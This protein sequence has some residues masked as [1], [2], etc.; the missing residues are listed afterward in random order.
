MIYGVILG[1]W[2]IAVGVYTLYYAF[3]MEKTGMIKAGWIIGRDTQLKESRDLP[4]FV[5]VAKK[6]CFI[7]GWL[8]SIG[9]IL[10]IFGYI[11][12]WYGV[13]A[14]DMLVLIIAYVWFSM[15]IRKAEKKY[16]AVDK[17]EKK[18]RKL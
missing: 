8:A 5:S 7:F 4:G 18:R 10:F 6:K 15:T 11:Y 9:G 1:V 13:L 2:M 12:D 17:K 3:M 16:L 14:V